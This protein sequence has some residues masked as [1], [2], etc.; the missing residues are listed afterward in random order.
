MITTYLLAMQVLGCQTLEFALAA[1]ATASS[2]RVNSKPTSDL[3][4]LFCDRHA[5]TSVGFSP[6]NACAETLG[7]IDRR[8]SRRRLR[9]GPDSNRNPPADSN[10][11]AGI[12][13]AYGT[14]DTA[15]RQVRER[16]E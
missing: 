15:Y 3:R 2:R 11:K 6:S 1:D 10:K 8:N 5:P 4:P 9:R 13:G 16:P 14:S 12:N 7:A